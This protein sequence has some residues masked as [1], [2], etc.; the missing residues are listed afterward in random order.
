MPRRDP[1]DDVEDPILYTTERERAV[2]Q[3]GRLHVARE[4]RDTIDKMILGRCEDISHAVE[5]ADTSFDSALRTLFEM[6]K[7]VAAIMRDCVAHD[8]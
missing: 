3:M 6:E 1:Q 8:R 2:Y 7:K 5:T 4:V